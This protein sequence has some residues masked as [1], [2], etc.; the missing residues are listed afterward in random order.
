MECA[1]VWRWRITDMLVRQ[2]TW[3]RLAS[4]KPQGRKRYLPKCCDCQ[5]TTNTSREDLPPLPKM[6]P[7]EPQHPPRQCQNLS[8][9]ADSTKPVDKKCI[10]NKHYLKGLHNAIEF[11]S[12]K[13]SRELI[14]KC[15]NFIFDYKSRAAKKREGE[16]SGLGGRGRWQKT[17]AALQTRINEVVPNGEG[18][19]W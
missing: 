17:P 12:G 15:M 13:N 7:D 2:S 8:V 14:K 5:E 16:S 18:V 9:R 4:V 19:T 1:R 11:F 6:A 10:M 3:Q